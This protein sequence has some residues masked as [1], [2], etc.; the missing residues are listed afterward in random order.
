MP[1]RG[2]VQTVDDQTDL[3]SDQFRDGLFTADQQY[4]FDRLISQ[5]GLS[6]RIQFFRLEQNDRLVV[7]GGI[8][9]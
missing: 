9:A 3:L 4:V 2:S 6:D 8:D 1:A 7:D 5:V